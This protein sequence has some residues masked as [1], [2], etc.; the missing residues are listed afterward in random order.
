MSMIFPRENPCSKFRY[1]I[2]CPFDKAPGI[3]KGQLLTLNDGAIPNIISP[4][5]GGAGEWSKL[6]KKIA[7]VCEPYAFDIHPRKNL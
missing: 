4:R 5:V 3:T 1:A 2:F 7:M 6:L